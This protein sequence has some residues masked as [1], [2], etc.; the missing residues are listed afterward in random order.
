[1]IRTLLITAFL[2]IGLGRAVASDGD[3]RVIDDADRVVAIDSH[4]SRVAV[5]APFG[6]EL[7]RR[8]GVEPVA[9]P[10]LPDG[11]ASWPEHWTGTIPLRISHAPGPSLEQLAACAPDLIISTSAYAHTHDTIERSLGVPVVTMDIVGLDDL[12]RH[13]E[14]LGVLLGREDEAASAAQAY[15]E[16]LDAALEGV[17]AAANGYSPRVLAIFGGARSFYGFLPDSYV[18]SVLDALGC[19]LT[20]QGLE[21]HAIYSDLTPLSLEHA[22]AADPDVVLVLGHGGSRQ[23][24]ASILNDRAWASLR[25]VREGRV[26]GLPDELFVIRPGT[27]PARAIAAVR[28]AVES[29]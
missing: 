26:V 25:A 4:A 18:G 15:R 13:L 19:E 3:L 29:D 27:E 2:L 7:M 8:L 16:S 9:A 6:T 11:S 10:R 1:M 23:T 21:S 17:P 28:A 22:V 24:A 14:T 5:V 20:T 12:S